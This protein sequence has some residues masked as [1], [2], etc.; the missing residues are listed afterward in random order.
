MTR[1]YAVFLIMF[2]AIYGICT[3]I[4]ATASQAIPAALL[5]HE[6][7]RIGYG[8]ITAGTGLGNIVLPLIHVDVL[9]KNLSWRQS[10]L[11]LAG[12]TLHLIPLGLLV[13]VPVRKCNII[14]ANVPSQTHFNTVSIQTRYVVGR[15]DPHS[16][17]TKRSPKV[18]K[19]VQKMRKRGK[20]EKGRKL[21]K[22]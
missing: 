9:Q 11:I 5:P 1:D 22:K 20:S 19:R 6:L 4:T 3:S 7:F 13:K 2:G 17:K 12:V 16:T 18:G 14:F 10:W 8:I 21:S 15:G